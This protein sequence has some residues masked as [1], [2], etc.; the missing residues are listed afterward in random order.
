[1]K[2]NPISNYIPF[3]EVPYGGIIYDDDSCF[4]IKV[5]EIISAGGG[6]DNYINAISISGERFC[7]FDD[8]ENVSY[9]P[10]ASLNLI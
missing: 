9:Y 3:K 7:C 6:H 4:F 8:N 2:V 5:T 1:M 10:N